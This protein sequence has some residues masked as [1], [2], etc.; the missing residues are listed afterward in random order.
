MTSLLRSVTIP[1]LVSD[2]DR[3]ADLLEAWSSP[4]LRPSRSEDAPERTLLIL[5]NRATEDEIAAFESRVAA[6]EVVRRTFAAVHVEQAGLEGDADLYAKNALEARGRYGNKAGPNNLFFAAM[7][8]A[9]AFGGFTLQCEVDC[10]PIVPDWLDA[11]EQVVGRFRG[12]WVLGSS[13]SGVTPIAKEIQFH[14]NG[15]AIYNVGDE[16]FQSFLAEVWRTRLQQFVRIDPNLA[17]DCWWENEIVR[18][19]SFLQ[20]KSFRYVS[21][22]GARMVRLPIFANLLHR[23]DFERDIEISREI[24]AMARVEPLFLHAG[25]AADVVLPYVRSE[26]E[27]FCDHVEKRAVCGGLDDIPDLPDHIEAAFDDRSRVQIYSRQEPHIGETYSEV[28]LTLIVTREGLHVTDSV[29]VRVQL[30]N[31]KAQIEFRPKRDMT[32]IVPEGIAVQEDK[33]GPAIRSPVA[34]DQDLSD[35]RRVV[36]INDRQYNSRYRIDVLFLGIK[37]NWEELRDFLKGRWDTLDALL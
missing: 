33:W 27:S 2:L 21:A 10:F 36:E 24:A 16:A 13:Y 19:S 30:F 4:K 11:L 8:R 5:L 23:K 32:L 22:F 20:N 34:V 14:I 35:F 25:F 3:L 28:M 37:E 12:A 31:G 1:C 15:N 7:E 26:D 6:F 18:A 17:Y 9:H 29:N